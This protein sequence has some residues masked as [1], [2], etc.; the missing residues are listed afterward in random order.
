MKILLVLTF[1]PFLVLAQSPKKYNFHPDSIKQKELDHRKEIKRYKNFNFSPLQ[2]EII[3][4]CNTALN[5]EYLTFEEKEFILLHNLA[6][7]NP[8][9]FKIY[10]SSQYDSSY[11]SKIV[12]K[13]KN[14]NRNLLQPDKGLFKSATE[15]AIKSGKDGTMGHQ[16]FDKRIFK[17][18]RNIKKYGYIHGENCS[19]GDLTPIEHFIMLLNSPGHYKNIMTPSYSFIGVSMQLHS[20]MYNNIVTCFSTNK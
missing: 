12:P 7:T 11:F 20:T 10:I 3:N 9:F 14:I 8:E 13:I 19:Y 4:K 16:N 2:Q 6:R 1:L 17:Y 18:N 15:H 5:V